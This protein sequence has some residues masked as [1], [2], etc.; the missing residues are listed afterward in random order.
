MTEL[1]A[2][3]NLTRN[4]LIGMGAGFIVGAFFFYTNIT[5]QFFEDFFSTYI[6]SL[7]GDIFKNLLRLIVVPLVFFSLVS[8]ISSLTD[9]ARLGLSLIHIS[10]PTRPY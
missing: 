6:F 7:G 5:P 10:E 8:G 1:S 2:P 4:V 9:M 3:K